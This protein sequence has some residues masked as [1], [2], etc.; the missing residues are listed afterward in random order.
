MKKVALAYNLNRGQSEHEVEFDSQITIDRL[1][2]SINQ[3]YQCIP[4]ECR[5]NITQWI[6]KLIEENHDITFNIAEG[7]RGAAREAFYPALF[8]QINLKYTGPGPTE[9]LIT[10]NKGLTKKLLEDREILLPWSSVIESEKELDILKN[11]HI[12]FPLII[13]LNS[14]GSSLGMDEN[15]IV[16]NWNALVVQ[17]TKLWDKFKTNVI[18]EQYIPG[19]DIS[20]TYV[21]GLGSLGPVEYVCPN[22]DIYDFR[23]KGVDN[24]TI[25]VVSPQ[26]LSQ[27]IRSIL[28]ETTNKITRILDI[29]GYCRIDY[30]MD[31]KDNIYFLEVNG[32][33]SFHPI[34]AFVL[35]GKEQGYEFDDLVHHII[36]FS[37]K[38]KRRISRAGIRL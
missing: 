2:E 21:E 24:D 11:E 17:L 37:I 22:S 16:D 7:F 19:R 23:L 4:I 9:L 10:H 14:E 31:Q 20:T 15:C 25:D 30:R 34:G 27:N 18:I 12:P 5:E 32:Q 28:L 1:I 38:N 3:K 6:G 26:N 35:A 8:E 13:K 33:V 29:N 36:D